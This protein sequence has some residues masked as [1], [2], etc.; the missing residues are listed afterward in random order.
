MAA[1]EAD[2]QRRIISYLDSLG[3][4]QTKM[5]Q[6]GY[7]R[8]GIPDVL[9]V[10][11]GRFYAFEVKSPGAVRGV[12]DEQCRELWRITEAGGI[13]SVVYGVDDVARIISA[14]EGGDVPAVEMP[15]KPARVHV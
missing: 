12:T 15:A 4:W 5:H 6:T 2:I 1:R 9:C 10:L 8:R 11:D 14:V 13:A 3:A 7:G